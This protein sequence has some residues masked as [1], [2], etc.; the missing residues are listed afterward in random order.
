MLG[1]PCAFPPITT[2][3]VI[4]HQET[5]RCHLYLQRMVPSF[6]RDSEIT[7]F[8]CDQSLH[9]LA[10]LIS[11]AMTIRCSVRGT[12]GELSK[13]VAVY[14]SLMFLILRLYVGQEPGIRL[15]FSKFDAPASAHQCKH[16]F[17]GVTIVLFSQHQSLRGC[18]LFLAPCLTPSGATIA[19][20]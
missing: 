10:Q 11:A 19:R 18:L 12:S 3:C 14:G 5:A 20:V 8:K 9:S 13:N 1:T 6:I 15:S 16:L 4:H 17:R 2:Q 7:Y